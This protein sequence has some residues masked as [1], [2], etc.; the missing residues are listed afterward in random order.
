MGYL[1]RSFVLPLSY[2][3]RTYLPCDVSCRR[4]CVSAISALSLPRG[5]PRNLTV[6]SIVVFLQRLLLFVWGWGNTPVLIYAFLRLEGLET[7]T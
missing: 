3:C 2:T 4:G 6:A 5:F 1:S 7:K